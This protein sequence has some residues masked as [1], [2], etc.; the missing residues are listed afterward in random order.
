MTR[1][2][3][4]LNATLDLAAQYGL[5]S[6][7]LTQIA[8][9]VNMR[10]PSLYNHFKSKD[11]VIQ[12]AYRYMREQARGRSIM[13][14]VDLG[15]LFEGRNLEEI[16]LALFDQ[17]CSVVLDEDLL[18]LFVVLYAERTTSPSAARIILD[19]TDHMVQQV[20]ALFRTLADRGMLQCDDVDMAA[21]SFAM[22]V[23]ALV[24]RQ[25]DEL[26]A[27]AADPRRGQAT[28][29]QAKSYISWFSR[30]MEVSHA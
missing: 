19:E 30:Q 9:R 8:E 1:K 25:L 13:P 17:Y 2:E 24:D 21:L 10:K 7:T 5:R 18:R 29:D 26:C 27:I 28:F 14:D 6:V 15:A 23:H 3:Q 4:I 16:L 22:T 11:E 20:T 12:E